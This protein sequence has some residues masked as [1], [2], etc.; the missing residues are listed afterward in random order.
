MDPFKS[1]LNWS[2]YFM[3]NYLY[4]SFGTILLNLRVVGGKNSPRDHHLYVVK[5]FLDF[6]NLVCC[7]VEL[8]T[9]CCLQSWAWCFVFWSY[10]EA[11]LFNSNIFFFSTARISQIHVQN[12]LWQLNNNLIFT[13][14]SFASSSLTYAA[15]SSI[16]SIILASQ[17]R[18]WQS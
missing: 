13:V 4:S 7:L 10:Y 5:N 3:I 17:E 2:I 8:Y 18:C 12:F 15:S 14:T 16:Q 6:L 1:L 11:L 9:Y